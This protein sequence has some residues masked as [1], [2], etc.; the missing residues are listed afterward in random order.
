[1]A[2]DDIRN[3]LR[4]RMANN[5]KLAAQEK[6]KE[7]EEPEQPKKAKTPLKKVSSIKKPEIKP[8]VKPEAKPKAKA[9]PKEI[10]IDEE[11]LDD[12]EKPLKTRDLKALGI[13]P[14]DIADLLDRKEAITIR[15]LRDLGVLEDEL[16]DDYDQG[17]YE[18]PED[19]GAEDEDLKE[20]NRRIAALKGNSALEK[21]RAVGNTNDYEVLAVAIYALT[22]QDSASW[23]EIW[24][25]LPAD[26]LTKAIARVSPWE[27]SHGATIVYGAFTN[28][29]LS[30]DDFNALVERAKDKGHYDQLE[31]KLPAKISIEAAT[32]LADVFVPRVLR[33][34]RF[35]VPV[36]AQNLPLHVVM[37]M[38]GC[39][40][41]NGLYDDTI[42]VQIL[43][44]L[45][46]QFDD[47][48]RSNSSHDTVKLAVMTLNVVDMLIK[49]GLPLA[50]SVMSAAASMRAL[51]GLG[52]K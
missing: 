10:E 7:S 49:R 18:E 50:G 19:E 32:R 39:R 35:T 2:I 21:M 37:M 42:N 1:M 30:T 33:T 38:Y 28:P 23:A 27:D 46:S 14:E 47:W 6:E 15:K 40:N 13:D 16:E 24:P 41:R 43:L 5:S 12:D 11:D 34:N 26:L 20:R 31:S 22:A 3:R 51:A 29:N 4:A 52:L 25:K 36:T 9:K 45:T 44:Q 48:A 8:E 17:N